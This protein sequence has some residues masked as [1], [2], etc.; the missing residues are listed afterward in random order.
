LN[1]I[2]TNIVCFLHEEKEKDH[3]TSTEDARPIENP[4]PTLVLGN[5]TADHGGEIVATSQEEGI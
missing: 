3:G 5:E 2:F 1:A 4:L